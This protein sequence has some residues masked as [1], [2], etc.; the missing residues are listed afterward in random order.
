MRQ[1]LVKDIECLDNN[2]E[3]EELEFYDNKITKIQNISHLTKLKYN[4]TGF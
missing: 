4:M 1:N 2:T 3:L